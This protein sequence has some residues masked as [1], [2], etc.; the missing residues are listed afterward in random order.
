MEDFVREQE[1]AE[2]LVLRVLRRYVQ[3]RAVWCVA[4]RVR[5]ERG[6]NGLG[7]A[8]VDGVAACRVHLFWLVFGTY[9]RDG[10]RAG[11]P[12]GSARNRAGRWR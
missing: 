12:M 1:R 3:V 2:A 4:V 10:W 6:W 5:A 9:D 8:E 7:T 11:W